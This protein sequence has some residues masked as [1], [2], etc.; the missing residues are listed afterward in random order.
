MLSLRQIDKS[1]GAVRALRSVDLDLQ[2]G[3]VHALVGENGA[4]KSTLLRILSGAMAPDEGSIT[5]DG[6]ALTG[7]TPR[8]AQQLGI[9]IVH[10]HPALLHELSVCEN[11]LFGSDGAWISWAKR[12]ERAQHL[13]DLVGA[14]IDPA[15]IVSTLPLPE[16]QLVQLARALRTKPRVLILDEPTAVLPEAAAQRLLALVR[17]LR[18]AGT[19]VLYVSHRLEELHQLADQVTVLRDGQ[20]VWCSPMTAVTTQD[21]IRHMVGR[22]VE[23]TV[24]PQRTAAGA[25]LLT[26]HN[27]T[28]QSA[29]LRDV[30]LTLHAGEVLGLAGLVG[31]GRTQLAECL[32]GL[33]SFEAGS[34][35][36]QGQP[37]APRSPADAIVHGVALVPEDRR[38]HGVIPAMSLTDN[39]TLPHLTEFAPHGLIDEANAATATQHAVH[40]FA[41]RAASVDDPIATLS[42][43]NQQKLVLARR[44]RHRPTVL[45]LDEPTQGIDVGARAEIHERIRNA[46]QAGT[47]VLLIS[48]DLPELFQLADRIAVLEQGCLRGIVARRDTTPEQVMSMCVHS[49]TVRP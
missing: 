7:L 23:A 3:S 44:L 10:Q 42:G 30:S 6:S 8:R 22:P 38:R 45:I 9:A 20:R 28:C 33:R 35:H 17:D 43:G 32:F 47:A 13:L 2:P 4:G 18:Q 16:Q 1:F 19:A 14:S 31:A 27:L 37:F 39:F 46:A 41:V 25:E 40:E 29:G 36:L 21:L 49:T 26:I 11:L 15:A 34:M 48:S 12:R 24:A 5:L